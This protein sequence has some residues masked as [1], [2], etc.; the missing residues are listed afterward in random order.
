[1]YEPPK[2]GF[3]VDHLNRPLSIYVFIALYGLSVTQGF[4]GLVVSG[5]FKNIDSELLAFIGFGLSLYIFIIFK[6]WSSRNWARVIFCFMI[7]F[8]LYDRLS[9]SVIF[10]ENYPLLSF[11]Q[12]FTA[13][14]IL[15]SIACLFTKSAN[16]FFDG[17]G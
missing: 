14:T 16:M 3:L 4:I 17:R 6:I 11:L 2:S 8:D 10:Y 9:S 7:L 15:V 12:F 13:V 5:A 1:M